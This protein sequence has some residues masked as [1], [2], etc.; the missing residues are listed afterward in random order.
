VRNQTPIQKLLL[1][2]LVLLAGSACSA[3]PQNLPTAAPTTATVKANTRT[4]SPTATVTITPSPYATVTA[5]PTPTP[6]TRVCSPLAVQPLDKIKDIITQHF[7]MPRMMDDGTYKD[8]AHHGVDLGYYT[9]NGQKFTETPVL[10]AVDGKIAAIIHNRPPYGNMI[11]LETTFEHIPRAL[12]ASE[13]IPSGYSLYSLY[14]HMQNIQPFELGEAVS[15]G[16]QLAETGLTGFTGGPHLHFE[17][18]WGPAGITFLVMG[19]YRADL[20]PEEM[21]NYTLWRMSGKFHLF[22]PIEL[23][24]PQ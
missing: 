9:R 13:N 16:Q 21:K 8:D 14:A 10:A 5:A 6:T 19:F 7:D 24:D 1:L 17:T 23:L 18:R 20:T 12:V 4:P 3:L 11:I 2:V 15:C 22:N